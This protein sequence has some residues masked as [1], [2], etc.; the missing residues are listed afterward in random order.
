MIRIAICDDDKHTLSV[1][2]RYI[3]NGFK[4]HTDEFIVK[5]YDNGKRL[6]SDNSFNAFDVLFLDID[7]PKIS[8]F[9]IAQKL[10]SDFS[11]C[12]IIFVTSHSNLV[13]DSLDYQPFHFIQKN[14]PKYLEESFY[15]VIDKLMNHMKQN[16][17]ITLENDRE[18]VNIYFRNIVYIESDKHYL[19]Y[20][21]QNREEPVLIRGTINEMEKALEIY[22]FIRIHRRFIVNLRYIKYIDTKIGKVCLNFNG[23]SKSLSLGQSYKTRVNE[24]YGI[25]LRDTL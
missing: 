16:K 21:I 17:K 8:G 5:C 4:V 19:N 22:S 1:L 23:K 18:T 2:E 20:Y 9:D 6:L 11:R 10:R 24:I 13:Y 15:S 14:P 7:M 3:S 12:F 25:Y